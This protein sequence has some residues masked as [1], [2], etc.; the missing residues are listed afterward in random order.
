MVRSM[1]AVVVLLLVT[2]GDAQAFGK[3]RQQR[4][5][6]Q[7]QSRSYSASSQSTSSSCADGS[8]SRSMTTTETM[9]ETTIT[10]GEDALDQ[11]NAARARR[12]LRPYIRDENLF[13]GALSCARARAANLI[14][15]HTQNDFAYLPP[16]TSAR[17]GGAGGLEPSW[18]FQACTVFDN[19]TYAGAAWVRGRDGRMYSQIFV[20]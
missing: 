17:A 16:G 6:P 20:R 2:T 4:Q 3:R 8:C 15:G 11:V 12:G 19:Y 10:T 1:F 5:Q 18:G 14:R 13:R 7:Y 9:S